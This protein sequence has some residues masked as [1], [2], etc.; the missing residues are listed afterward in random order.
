MR[1]LLNADPLDIDSEYEVPQGTPNVH[2]DL[3]DLYLPLEG[4]VD[5]EVEVV[6]LTKEVEKIEKEIEK[7]KAKLN[8]PRFTEKAPAS[9]VDEHHKRLADW[10]EQLNHN[11]KNLDAAKAALS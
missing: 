5:F 8:N 4:L 9:V 6:R 2:S 11:Q 7:A 10:A 3:G 1:I